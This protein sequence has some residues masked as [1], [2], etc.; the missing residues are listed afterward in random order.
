MPFPST[1]CI[2]QKNIG[3]KNAFAFDINAS[4]SGFLYALSI[5]G[6]FI[7]MVRQIQPL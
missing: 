7:K 3:A 4:C 1:A 5:A 6:M 2:V